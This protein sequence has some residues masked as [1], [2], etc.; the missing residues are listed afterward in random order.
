MSISKLH[1]FSKDTDAND[2]IRGYQYQFLKTLETWLSN[3][4][5][6]VDDD[7]YCDYEDDIFQKNEFNNTAKFRQIKLYSSNFSFSSEE[8]EKSI[9]HFFMLHVKTDFHNLDK[10]FVFEVNSSIARKYGNNRAE[11]LREWNEN[12]NNISQALLDQ[13]CE[14][15]KEIV[16]EYIDTETKRLEDKMDEALL[17]E[18]LDGF[19]T[20]SDEDWKEFVRRIKWVFLNTAPEEE[21]KAIKE[22]INHLIINLPYPIRK[23]E[24]Q[25]VF[26][27]L[28]NIVLEKA[29]NKNPDD[30][31][32]VLSELTD[33]ILELGTEKDN[34][35]KHVRTK[36]GDI[37]ELKYFNVGEFFEVIDAGNYC[38]RKDYLLKDSDLWISLLNIF[39]HKLSISREFELQAVYEYIWLRIQL[40]GLYKKPK[41][42]LHGSEEYIR[43]YF[44]DFKDFKNAKDIEDAQNILNIAHMS[45]ILKLSELDTNDVEDWVNQLEEVLNY[46]IDIADNPS[47]KCHLLENK[48]THKLLFLIRNDDCENYEEFSRPID[49]LLEIVDEAGY[50]NVSQIS[51][52]LTTFLELLIKIAT[53]RSHNLIELLEN[54][55][56]KLEPIVLRR[57][58]NYD[59]AKIQIRKGSAFLRSE[60]PKFILKALDCFH[61]AKD[62]WNQQETIDGLALALINIAQLYSGMGLNLAA[63]Y[64][65]LSCAW[66]SIYNLENKQLLKRLVS[67]LGLI[68]HSEFK[69]G[70]WMNAISA[71]YLYWKA[72]NEF[73]PNPISVEGDEFYLKKMAD[74]S[75]ILHSIPILSAQLKFFTDVIIKN[76]GDFTDGLIIEFLEDLMKEFKAE[77]TLKN[78][79]ERKLYDAPLTDVGERRMIRFNALGSLWTI[80]FAN[81]YI[82]NSI[83]EEFCA[84]LQIILGEIALSKYDFHLFKSTIVLELEMSEKLKL[85]EQEPS[86]SEYRWKVFISF[87]EGVKPNEVNFNTASKVASIQTILNSISLLPKEEFDDAFEELFKK[88]GLAT[89]TLSMNSYQKMYRLVFVKE[90][91]ELSQR[92]NFN[93]VENSLINLPKTNKILEWESGLSP[94]Y[95]HEEALNFISGRYKNTLK[96]IHLTL[97]K[98]I[99]DKEFQSLINGFRAEGWQDWQILIAI[100]NFIIN[101]KANEE[102]IL[103]DIEKEEERKEKFFE[104][105][106]K[107]KDMKEEES[108]MLFPIVAFESNDFLFHLESSVVNVLETYNFEN[109]ATFPNFQAIKEFLDIRLNMSED[110]VSEGNP[111]SQIKFEI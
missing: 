103:L 108:Y 51:N 79:I 87:F 8:I 86:H 23:E 16:T 81:D 62:L 90:E 69:Q 28:Y 17:N 40:T 83:A 30:R 4:L 99:S 104:L 25:S 36:W 71:Y 10:E 9:A 101:H 41:G 13:C 21:L 67:S 56:N 19:N 58:S 22:R 29:S 35:Y 26:G 72:R 105:F 45:S 50:Y 39:I 64:Y 5:E 42:N 44:K 100:F 93:P 102:L 70:S 66:V 91:F 33:V 80:T 24:I 96:C 98:L 1:I 78:I 65:A 61:K 73:N 97:A 92:Q 110:V 20:I 106:H 34:W 3:Y 88:S 38:R 7:I 43:N 63:K 15:V 2:A 59:A 47:E 60:N 53:E 55:L 76:F 74:F 52:R 54:Y 57:G 109:K 11:L 75:L 14:V 111:L 94:K 48:A 77:Q 95:N 37:T 6:E 89:K 84:I 49:K 46:Q 68:F 27:A 18:A 32:L 12:Q 82:T 31:K 85:P 107:Y